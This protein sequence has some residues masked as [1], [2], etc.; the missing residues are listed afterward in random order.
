[1][2]FLGILSVLQLIALPGLLLIRLFAGK[3]GAIQ[4]ALF[5]FMLSLLANYVAVF[6]LVTVRLYLRP[7]VLAL[8]VLEFAAVLWL[9]RSTLV[10]TI[11]LKDRRDQISNS[12]KL[13][14]EW[15][16]KD[17]LKA[18]LYLFFT[19]IAV[20]AILWVVWVWVANFN[21]V[22]QNWDAYASW[23]RWAIKWADNRIP[24]DTWEYP[25]L[26]PTAFSLPYKF[27]GTI[28][29]KFF[30][31]SIMPLFT[32][33]IGL[34]LFDLGRKYRSFGYMLAAGFA[35]YT[36]N[37]FLGEYIADAHCCERTV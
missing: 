5:V 7:V 15:L 31:K 3:R 19:V 24:G 14:G 4:Q 37:L 23:D 28:A 13:F 18:S 20:V 11:S 34:M 1:M 33:A 32:L 25:Q 12:V 21:T 29:V 6:A 9:Y 17:F 27:I 8:F 36:I 2:L 22:F 16:S 30:G 35:I 10:G 26:I